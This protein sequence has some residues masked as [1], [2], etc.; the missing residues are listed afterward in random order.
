MNKTELVEAVADKTSLSRSTAAVAVEAVLEA[1]A[2]SL[3]AGEPVT[4][5]GFGTFDVRERS[6]RTGRNPRTGEA[7]QVAA[8]RVPT[9]RAG[10]PL[11]DAVN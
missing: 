2:A 7:I 11:R 1:V 4:V 8:S 6:A 9:F 3:A 10:K 5:P